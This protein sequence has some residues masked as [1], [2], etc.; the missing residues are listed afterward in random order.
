MDNRPMNEQADG[1]LLEGN[2]KE[3]VQR[4]H[5]ILQH[6]TYVYNYNDEYDITHHDNEQLLGDLL[7]VALVIS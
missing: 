3:I 1:W 5:T 7:N 4:Q 2:Y 6:G